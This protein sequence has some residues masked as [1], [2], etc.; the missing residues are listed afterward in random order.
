MAVQEFEAELINDEESGGA[1]IIVPP[2][3]VAALGGKGRI[4]VRCTIDGRPYRGSIH[5]YGGIHYLGVLKSIRE[6][7]QDK[8]NFY[9][10]GTIPVTGV[11]VSHVGDVA[12]LSLIEDQD[13]KCASRAYAARPG[14][15]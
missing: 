11:Q 8:H 14:A 13:K 7:L 4:K 12:I 9:R 3:I 6:S 15:S 5:P 2:A 1:G 10:A